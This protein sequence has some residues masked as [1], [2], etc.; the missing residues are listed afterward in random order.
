MVVRGSGAGGG[1][2]PTGPASEAWRD[3]ARLRDILLGDLLG[4]WCQMWPWAWL[5][6]GGAFQSHAMC[7]D[8]NS[9]A[10]NSV[11]LIQ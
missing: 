10:L 1:G 7:L 5:S 8:R 11:C 9:G 3:R 6:G 2:C 4:V